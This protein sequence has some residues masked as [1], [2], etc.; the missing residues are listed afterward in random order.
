L[1]KPLNPSSL[2]AELDRLLTKQANVSA[3]PDHLKEGQPG[4]KDRAVGAS[5]S[6]S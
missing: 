6:D 3:N 2:T 1:S 4:G 5:G